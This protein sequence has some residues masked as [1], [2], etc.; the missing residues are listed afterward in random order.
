MELLQRE[1]DGIQ[2]ALRDADQLRSRLDSLV[3]VYPFND[4]RVPSSRLLS[5]L[6]FGDLHG[7]P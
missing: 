1:L 6:R 3:S 5:A 7:E 4:L 2:G